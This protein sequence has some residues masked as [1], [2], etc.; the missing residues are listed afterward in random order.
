MNILH[1]IF[2]ILSICSTDLY[3]IE[4]QNKKI[5]ANCKFF[6]A[7]KKKCSKFGN[8][9]II[10]G[11]HSY[12]RASIVRNDEDKCGEDAIFFKKNHFKFIT[13][14]YYFVL[15]NGMFLVSLCSFIE[16]ISYIM[17]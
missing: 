4:T 2:F 16:Y 11:K 13:L 7:N 9:S 17:K 8:V 1:Y 14:P 10:T 6:I 15:D 3:L 5:C 12:D